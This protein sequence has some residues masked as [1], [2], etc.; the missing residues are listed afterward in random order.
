VRQGAGNRFARL[1]RSGEI[2]SVEELKAAFRAEARESHPDLKGPEADGTAFIAVRDEYE[3]AL[4]NFER[5]RFGARSAEPG[6]LGSAAAEGPGAA[7]PRELWACLALLLKRGFPKEPRH[8]KERLRYEYAAWRF[9]RALAPAEREAFASWE[10]SLRSLRRNDAR[11]FA[12]LYA[13]LGELL[14]YALCGVDAMRVSLVIGLGRLGADPRFGRDSLA[15][16]GL[17]AARAGIGAML[18]G[19]GAGGS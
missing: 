11:A 1:I 18:G 4:A 9:S 6:A 10:E 16:L 19:R 12:L 15:F 3:A 8:E 5:H 13:L 2:G 7:D 17:L 14:E